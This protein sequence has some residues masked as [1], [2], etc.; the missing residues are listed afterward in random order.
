[1]ILSRLTELAR[2]LVGKIPAFISYPLAG[3][4]G[5]VVFHV[6]PRGRRNMINS[7]AQILQMDGNEPEVKN[8]ARQS[9]RNYGKYLVDIMRYSKPSKEFYDKHFKVE[10]LENLDAA[11]KEGKGVIL[12]GFH[13]GNLDLGVRYLGSRGYPVSAIV[14]KMRVDE[15]DKILQKPRSREGVK[16]ID[17]K[18]TSP[19]MVGILKRNEIL[20]LMIDC[21]NCI[22]G[23]KVKI[24]RGIAMVPTGA[25][26]LA[27][28]TGAKIVP[29]G[30]IRTS[31]TTFKGIL[32]KP[33]QYKSVGNLA[34]DVKQL[35]QHTVHSLEDFARSYTEQWYVYHPFIREHHELAESR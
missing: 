35:T 22:K 19:N 26:T 14:N 7:V 32:A 15:F 28:R 31:N 3:F 24:G 16:L 17:V 27:L 1:M 4:A 6:W 18:D 11:L 2:N 34:E 8:I 10:G 30:L 33:V 5:E 25:A 9:L 29:C 20:A 21:P 12:V 13:M 23:I